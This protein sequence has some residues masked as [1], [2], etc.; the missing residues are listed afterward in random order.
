MRTPRKASPLR[1]SRIG[2]A[3]QTAHLIHGTNKGDGE[4]KPILT[5]AWKVY[6][7]KLRPQL[8][9]AKLQSISLNCITNH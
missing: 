4:M 8:L 7:A 9:S 5:R 2:A 3:G 1:R 6:Q